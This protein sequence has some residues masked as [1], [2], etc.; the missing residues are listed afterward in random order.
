MANAERLS[1][2]VQRLRA[3]NPG[4]MTL[5][6]TNSYLVGAGQ[7]MAVIDPGPD[8]PSHL[9]DL[10][11]TAQATGATIGL[12]LI[13]HGHPDH[14][15]GA[16]KLQAMT[17]APIAAFKNAEF[18]HD[19]PLKDGQRVLVGDATLI[20]LYTPGHAVDHLC[21]FL[22]EEDALFTGD[23]ILGEGTTA[24][25]PPRGDMVA[26]LRSLHQ[27]EQD[28]GHA[29]VIYPGHGPTISDPTA[30]IQE[31]LQHRQLREQQIL[32]AIEGGKD[33]I[34]QI[35]AQ[36]YAETDK[37]LWPAAARQVMAHLQKLQQEG[38]VA[39]TEVGFDAEENALLNPDGLI[40]P[41]VAAELGFKSHTSEMSYRYQSS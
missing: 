13:T 11:D 21:Y 12:I 33:T 5:T 7:E 32:Q 15:P 1:E 9:Q 31:Y 2:M 27:L 24:I 36:I 20:A 25:A 22:E 40:D 37:R 10:V 4:P 19:L 26:Y 30:K 23:N 8:I 35:V 16:A 39:A 34:K 29:E 18:A 38:K 41:V 14:F 17:G 28:W 3:P 6:G